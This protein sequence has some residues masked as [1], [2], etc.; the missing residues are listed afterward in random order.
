MLLYRI[1]RAILFLLC[2]I[3]FRL[4]VRGR[5]FIP[6]KGGFVLASNHAS[7]LDPILLGTACNR[8]LNFAAKDALFK[9][10]LFAA[11]I[12][13]VGAFPIRR[14]SADIAAIRESVRRLQNNFGLV[15]F[16]EGS[17]N[18]TGEMQNISSGFVLIANKAGVPIVPAWITGSASALGKGMKIIRPAKIKVVFGKPVYPN[19]VISD[20]GNGNI[21][22]E[23]KL[24]YMN[25]AEDIVKLIKR[26]GS[27]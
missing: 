12:L 21:N 8:I 9:N 4:E 10:R 11:L 6:K 2:K 7:F 17:R 5:E 13:R 26:L 25:I 14:W 1:F 3:F 20:K 15:V 27:S 16:P 23:R 19:I 24:V 18:K 22:S